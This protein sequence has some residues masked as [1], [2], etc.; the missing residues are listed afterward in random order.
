LNNWLKET[1]NYYKQVYPSANGPDGAEWKSDQYYN[2]DGFVLEFTFEFFDRINDDKYAVCI[3]KLI[4]ASNTLDKKGDFSCATLVGGAANTYSTGSANAPI[5]QSWN[6]IS[7]TSLTPP[8]YCF[9]QSGTRGCWGS[10]ITQVIPQTDT[11]KDTKE[12]TTD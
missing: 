10:E 2:I 7:V 1:T 12:A 11:S 9:S 6:N 3:Q 4:D 5:N 8:H